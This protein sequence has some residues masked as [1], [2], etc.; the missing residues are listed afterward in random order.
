MRHA[1][2]LALW[3]LPAL[4]AAATVSGCDGRRH[5]D[6]A[7]PTRRAAAR[8]T[9]DGGLPSGEVVLRSPGRPEVRVRV[10]FATERRDIERGLMFRERLDPDAGM[11]FVFPPP[12]RRHVFWMRNTIIPLDMIFIADDLQVVGVVENAEPLTETER[13]VGAPSRYVLE[14]NA[15][16]A[17]RHGV[18]AGTRVEV[19][20]LGD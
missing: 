18:A 16:F 9:P 3:G 2:P 17:A 6:A 8:A 4:A 14:V 13:A 20:G 5:G 1:L 19:I 11:L 12:A 15:G 10:E 7:N